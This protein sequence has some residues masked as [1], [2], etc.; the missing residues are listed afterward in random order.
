VA[1]H[2]DSV[3]AEG[4]PPAASE[5]ES[6]GPSEVSPQDASLLRKARSAVRL[7][8]RGAAN[9]KAADTSDEWTD[10][11][12]FVGRP[13]AGQENPADT[14]EKNLDRAGG[15][16]PA[17]GQAHPEPAKIK[18]TSAESTSTRQR[19]GDGNG[20]PWRD[21]SSIFSSPAHPA[22]LSTSILMPTSTELL[23]F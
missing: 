17:H 7:D 2:H 23:P 22:P 14:R 13:H 6:E 18:D 5:A 20:E 3:S 19:P 1:T 4:V 10:E 11:P 15:V 9:G 21:P 16:N 8:I 12:E